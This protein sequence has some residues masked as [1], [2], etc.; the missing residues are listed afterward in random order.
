MIAAGISTADRRIPDAA[1][2]AVASI[3]AR[4]RRRVAGDATVAIP[5]ALVNPGQVVK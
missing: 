1:Q 2:S 3:L 5:T 4:R